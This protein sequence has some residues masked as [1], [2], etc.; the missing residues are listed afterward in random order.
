MSLRSKVIQKAASTTDPALKKA[1][2]EA[3]K[4][5]SDKVAGSDEL[6][7]MLVD[8]RA[9]FKL[10]EKMEDDAQSQ[11]LLDDI[12]DAL[13]REL[14]IKSGSMHALKRLINMVERGGNWDESLLRNN[15][16]KIANSLNIKLP[17]GM[18]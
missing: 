12:S 6:F 17:S 4:P 9:Y 14:D 8:Q 15:I 3:L 1:L 10:Y 18:F 11:E 2:L 5:S 16:F 13:H 7:W